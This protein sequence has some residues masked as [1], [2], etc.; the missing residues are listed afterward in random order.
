MVDA[1]EAFIVGSDKVDRLR[2]EINTGQQKRASEDHEQ[3]AE[4]RL[5]AP[6]ALLG[7]SC[8]LGD[9][10]LNGSRLIARRTGWSR[11]GQPGRRRAHLS[12]LSALRIGVELFQ[13]QQYDGDVVAAAG[14]V[15]C[16]DQSARRSRQLSIAAQD[17]SNLVVGDHRRQPI[18]TEQ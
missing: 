16:S 7:H 15:G 4:P 1:D 12:L 6:T 17:L 10:L 18:T 13:P 5:E 8:L 9:P 11:R 3:R 2:R 14:L